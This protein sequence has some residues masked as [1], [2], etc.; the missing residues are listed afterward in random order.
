M[1]LITASCT[2]GKVNRNSGPDEGIIKRKGLTHCA[3]VARVRSQL[4]SGKD[5]LWGSLIGQCAQQ[6]SRFVLK[7]NIHAEEKYWKNMDP[8]VN[9]N[10]FWELNF[11]K[12]VSL[13]LYFIFSNNHQQTCI[14][15]MAKP[16]QFNVS[17]NK[18]DSH[19]SALWKLSR[20]A[21]TARLFQ[22][23]LCPGAGGGGWTSVVRGLWRA[24]E[25]DVCLFVSAS[26]QLVFFQ[27]RHGS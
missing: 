23:R 20:R 10:H 12:N 3:W 22:R 19:H 8:K 15:L 27:L 16:N 24:H 25:D 18:A 9:S 2:R 14:I 21:Q 1:G 6:D 26:L 11:L 5:Q 17:E 13:S 4:H 7:T